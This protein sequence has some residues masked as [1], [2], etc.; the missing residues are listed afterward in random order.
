MDFHDRID[1]SV[2]VC[3]SLNGVAMLAKRNNALAGNASAYF[4]SIP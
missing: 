2:V 4:V 1:V 3:S